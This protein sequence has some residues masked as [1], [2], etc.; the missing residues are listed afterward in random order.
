MV[1]YSYNNDTFIVE[2]FQNTKTFASFLPAVAGTRGKPLWA[3]YANIGQCMGGFGV[4]SKETPITPFDSATLAYQNIPTRS[5]RSFIK[6]NGEV[7]TPFFRNKVSKE[8]M[9]VNKSDVTITEETDK[10]EY[11]I[12]YSSVPEKNFAALIRKVTIISKVDADYEVVDGLPIFFPNGL[13]NFCYKELISLMAAY[14]TVQ[15]LD[16]KTPFVKFKTSTG[17]NTIVKETVTGNGFFT[18]DM[19]D[20]RLDTIVDLQNVF[21]NDTTLIDAKKFIENEYS[22]FVGQ[23]Q[24]TENKLPCAFATFKRHFNANEEYSFFEIFGMFD[25]HEYFKTARELK[26]ADFDKMIVRT[27]ELI[28]NLLEPCS[29]HTGN[30]AF[31]MYSKQTY[32][33]NNLRGGFPCLL[34]NGNGG[35]V[36]YIY[37]RKH[38]D[39]E[40]DYN[41]FIIPSKY[42]SSGA[43]NFRD[44]NQNR[45]NDLFFAPYVK[46][47]NVKLFF[48]L[49]QVDGQ[50]PLNVK[51]L[52]FMLDVEYK[53]IELPIES[54][55]LLS[56]IKSVI[57]KPFEP[58]TLYTLLRDN[59]NKYDYDADKIFASILAKSH[60]V[61]EANFAEGYWIDHWTYN[62]DLL[63]NYRAVY[64]DK[65]KALL[66]SP[67]YKYFYSPVFVNPRDEKCSLLPDGKIRQYGAI[68]LK[69][70]K[71]ECERLKL[72]IKKTY[73]L[74]N[75]SDREVTTTLLSKIYNL[76]LIKFS[77]LDSK[78]LG[79]EME[80]EKPGWNDAMNGLP[81]LF[82]SALSESVELL[83][84]V[85]FLLNNLDEKDADIEILE[86]QAKFNNR[87]MELLAS[88]KTDDASL[89]DYWDKTTSAREDF[90]QQC[91][92]RVSGKLATLT[93][94][95]ILSNLN[96]MADVLTDGIKRA[97]EIGNGIL[98][99][100]L[101]Y[102]VK[103]FELTGH[104]NH[105]GYKTVKIKSFELVTLPPF[106]EA[107]ARALKLGEPFVSHDD[108]DV[109]N[110]TALYDSTLHFYKTCA[111]IDDAPFEIGRV[112]AFT[113]GWLEREC[114]F[115]HMTYK[116][117]LGL[118][119]AGFYD[120]FYKEAKTNFVY[121][122]KTEVYGRSILENSS[123]IV[124]TCNPDKSNHGRG[125]FARL[126][127][128]NAEFLNILT[129][130]FLGE[131]PFTYHDEVLEFKPEPKLSAEM[132]DENNKA[133]FRL[134]NTT[135]LI[136]INPLKLDCYKGVN[137]T[138]A[139]DGKDVGDKI[140]GEDANSIRQGQVKQ[141]TITIGEIK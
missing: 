116:Y 4:D 1:K 97:K 141:I 139:I 56:K 7:F 11:R 16:K 98:P 60:Q 30:P 124:P 50:N 109:I 26:Y 42:Y 121:N 68:D 112:H 94:K 108:H 131:Y 107:S 71:D 79:I 58:S 115:V 125:F 55:S 87:I 129:I 63:I 137:L 126:T 83:R 44:V 75:E 72:D 34:D 21:G 70:L 15:D 38:G 110:K 39:M 2:D 10:Y 134:F 123:F 27:K 80:C 33:D 128:A 52:C 101:V 135:E 127:G 17:D 5:F 69:G 82:A 19:N 120:Q 8:T 51:P 37:S 9:Y 14:C 59:A 46:D 99:S 25:N 77:T 106:L 54:K 100:Y 103:D 41:S 93:A 96:K 136:Y 133:S 111:D 84:L 118:L 6:I 35:E 102:N 3:F 89:F 95:E 138:Y 43:G 29:V 57:K 32:L 40:R 61:I 53:T 104:V 130:L 31:D 23:E 67:N 117:M 28:D 66:Y 85:K 88:R 86:E 114:N 13:S 81:G 74:K 132:F 20:K 36:Y 18:R 48:N 73:W 91:H 12:T 64:P 119:K 24:Q 140:V 22:E 76:I 122:M 92:Y 113:K 78:G 62:V 65:V 47:Y 105:L 90:R 49:I 45:R